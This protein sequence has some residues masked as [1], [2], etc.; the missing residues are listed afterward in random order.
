MRD[1][2]SRARVERPVARG[3]TAEVGVVLGV[4]VVELERRCGRRTRPSGRP[5]GRRRAARTAGRPWC[6][7]RPRGGSGRRAARSP[8]RCSPARCSS[9][10]FSRERASGSHERSVVPGRRLLRGACGRSSS[11]CSRSPCAS[12]CAGGETRRSAPSSSPRPRSPS[13]S[14]SPRSQASSRRSLD[15][16]AVALLRH[17][18]ARAGP[19]ADSLHRGRTR[20]RGRRGPRSSSAPGRCSPRCSRSPARRAVHAGLVAGTV[21]VVAA[22]W[23]SPANGSRPEDFHVLGAVLALVV[24]RALRRPRQRRA[25]GGRRLRSAHPRRDDRDAPGRDTRSRSAGCS[26]G[27]ARAW[28]PS[29]DSRRCLRSLRR[30]SRSGSPTRRSSPRSTGAGDGR[31]SAQ[32]DAVALGVVLR[33]TA[34]RQR[35]D[36]RPP[37]RAR[38]RPRRRRRRH[39]RRNSLTA[40]ATASPTSAVV[41]LPPT[42]R[43]RGPSAQTRLQRR[44]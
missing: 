19:L 11:A 39:H 25:L 27:A 20:T 4:L 18:T 5:R 13:C 37:D 44:P 22:G 8:P 33:G 21:L 10:I 41:R 38:R 6:R 2:V 26:P 17:R 35:G 24:R 42:S 30:G 14:P 15:R 32:R 16:R 9:M 1:A 23:L 34:H 28:E 7:S 36:D 43:V 31:R 12:V 40:S 29:Y 3:P